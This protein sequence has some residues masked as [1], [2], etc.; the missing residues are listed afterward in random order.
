MGKRGNFES[1][2]SLT[3]Y[4]ARYVGTQA[5]RKKKRNLICCASDLFYIL[6]STLQAL[7]EILS[8]EIL[9]F[10]LEFALRIVV[11]TIHLHLSY[12]P[13]KKCTVRSHT[14]LYCDSLG[15]TH[16]IHLI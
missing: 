16:I 12:A 5:I 8:K 3:I 13:V 9:S 15:N 6:Y 2:H 7:R 14:V 10:S 4:C 11:I 1:G